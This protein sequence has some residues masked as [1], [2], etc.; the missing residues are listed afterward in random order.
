MGSCEVLGAAERL[1]GM[2]VG[3]CRPATSVGGLKGEAGTGD[4]GDDV[5][6][7]NDGAMG[8]FIV[9]MDGVTGDVIG[10]MGAGMPWPRGIMDLSYP[11]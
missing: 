7:G 5:I 1:F 2:A 4:T 3:F 6:E 9:D 10:A 11:M 8:D